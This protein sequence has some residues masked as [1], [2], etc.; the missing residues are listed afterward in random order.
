[1]NG[2]INKIQC[3]HWYKKCGHNKDISTSYLSPIAQVT[4]LTDISWILSKKRKSQD[5]WHHK[6]F[7]AFSIIHFC[8]FMQFGDWNLSCWCKEWTPT[9]RYG[10]ICRQTQRIGETK[11]SQLVVFIKPS[12]QWMMYF[13]STVILLGTENINFLMLLMRPCPQSTMM[14]N[15]G[16]LNKTVLM[17]FQLVVCRRDMIGKMMNIEK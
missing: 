11:Q 8:S 15:L 10:F 5:V 3:R 12:E 17:F 14:R 16:L 7:T 9:N 4:L 2:E 1:M 6:I 13:I